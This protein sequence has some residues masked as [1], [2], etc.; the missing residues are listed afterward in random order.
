MGLNG[1]NALD[2]N[3]DRHIFVDAVQVPMPEFNNNPDLVDP[4]VLVLVDLADPITML[5]CKV[6]CSVEFNNNKDLVEHS[7]RPLVDL[8][9]MKDS[10]DLRIK[11]MLV[12]TSFLSRL[13]T[14]PIRTPFCSAGTLSLAVTALNTPSNA[15]NEDSF[16]MI[17]YY[18]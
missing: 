6:K 17:I 10:E 7:S 9:T 13:S 3:Q 1:G 4:S 8:N 14:S 12:V 5:D 18:F 16:V 11:T 2:F 15:G